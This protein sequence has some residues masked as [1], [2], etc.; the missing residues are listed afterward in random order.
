M[1]NK[2]LYIIPCFL[3]ILYSC[4]S[5]PK[6]PEKPSRPSYEGFKWEIISGA[7]LKCWAQN[8]SVIHV[9]TDNTIPGA[10]IARGDNDLNGNIVI[11]IFPL[12]SQKIESILDT[13]K[14]MP[15]WDPSTSCAFKEIPSQR[16]GVKRYVLELTGTSA[17]K[18]REQSKQ[19]PIPSTCNGWGVGNSGMRYFE[20][21]SNQPNKAIFIEIGQDTPLFDEQSIILTNNSDSQKIN[22]STFIVQGMLR[23]GHEVRAFTADGDSTDYWIIDKTGKLMD[24]YEKA[25]GDEIKNGKPIHVKLRVKDMGKTDDGF[26]ADYQS[27]YHV[28]DIIEI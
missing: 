20:I 13:L 9:I 17:E 10:R 6:F 7:G 11:K 5:Y 12:P 8:N 26:A 27:V 1:K 21:H 2:I 14:K 4:T 25:T 28:I 22:D 24:A 18:F 23:I 3:I 16:K 19:E 15:G